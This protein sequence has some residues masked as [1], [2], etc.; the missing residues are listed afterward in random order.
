MENSRGF[1]DGFFADPA[2]L[3]FILVFLLLFWR[4]VCI[5]P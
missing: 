4:P 1:Y 2:I 5:D 3:F